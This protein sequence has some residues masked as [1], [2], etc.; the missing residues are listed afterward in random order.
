MLIYDIMCSIQSDQHGLSLPQTQSD[1]DVNVITTHLQ[2]LKNFHHC[3]PPEV[4]LGPL[5]PFPPQSDDRR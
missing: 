5:L 2:S 4:M 3:C 1:E